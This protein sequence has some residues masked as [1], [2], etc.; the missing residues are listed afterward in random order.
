MRFRFCGD[1]DAPD[2]IL[3]EV[4]ILSK[5]VWTFNYLIYIVNFTFN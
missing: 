3:A 4:N 5:F 2:W 1:L